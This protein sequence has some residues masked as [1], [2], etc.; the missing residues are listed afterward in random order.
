M[1]GILCL[2][3][4][5][6]GPVY[7]SGVGRTNG[8]S[9]CFIKGLFVGTWFAWGVATNLFGSNLA[10]Y[11]CYRL[12]AQVHCNAQFQF[13]CSPIQKEVSRPY[14]SLRIAARQA[15]EFLLDECI[16]QSGPNIRI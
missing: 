10:K 8:L 6:D 1:S 11:L 9:V 16:G 12:T 3:L 7:C 4:G 15:L 13:Q 5:T 2:Y 14:S